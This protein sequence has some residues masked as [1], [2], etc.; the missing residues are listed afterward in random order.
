VFY[1]FAARG[2]GLLAYL[3]IAGPT[4]LISLLFLTS[5]FLLKRKAG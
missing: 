2:Q 3:L 5:Y 1:I 4:F